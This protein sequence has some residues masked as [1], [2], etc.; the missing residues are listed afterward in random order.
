MSVVRSQESINRKRDEKQQIYDSELHIML[1]EQQQIPFLPLR[2]ET[3]AVVCDV[4]I[5]ERE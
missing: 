2:I 5:V 4:L 3:S 1:I